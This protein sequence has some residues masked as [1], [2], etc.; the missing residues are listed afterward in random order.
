[1]VSDLAA[2]P[3]A[4]VYLFDT[5]PTQLA[6]LGDTALP[7]NYRRRLERYRYGPGSFKLD[8]ALDGPI[9]WS[10]P[11]VNLA[12]TV[13]V[14]GTMAEIAQAELD[15]W[16]GRHPDKPFVLVVQQSEFDPARAPGGQHTGMRI[17]ARSF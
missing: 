2:L 4:K 5:D 1:M 10:D 14:G 13:H 7:Q 16:E 17:A 6:R 12:S 3:P 9:P 8:L 15:V 11:N